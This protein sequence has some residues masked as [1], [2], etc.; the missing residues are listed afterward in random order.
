[1]RALRGL[2][3]CLLALTFGAACAETKQDD[4]AS[5]NP[6]ATDTTGAELRSAVW[7]R[8]YTEC[9]SESSKDLAGKYRVER[10]PAAISTAVATSW[11]E[12]FKAGDD[13]LKSGVEGCLQGMK[14]R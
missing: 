14:S 3:I 6:S 12:R 2:V 10:T 11:K 8:A 7:E 5:S 9:A 13:V 1:M 4:A